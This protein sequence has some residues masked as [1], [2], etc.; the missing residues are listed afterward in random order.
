[1]QKQADTKDEG[2]KGS[3]EEKGAY[4]GTIDDIKGLHVL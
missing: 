4:R 3:Q 2:E 1:M